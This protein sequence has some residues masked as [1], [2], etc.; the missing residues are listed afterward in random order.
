MNDVPRVPS[1]GVHDDGRDDVHTLVGAYALDAVDDVDRARVER[2]LASCPECAEELRSL[3]ETAAR[4]GTAAATDPPPGL[5]ARVLAE[6]ARTRQLPPRP[7][8][9]HDVVPARST[10]RA[11]E[12]ARLRTATRWLAAA[13]S[14]LLV[15][16][17]GLGALAWTWRQDAQQARTEA[18][19]L[20]GVLANADALMEA[21]FSTGGHGTMLVSGDRFLLVGSQVPPPPDGRVYK[22]WFID[23]SGPRPS[24]TLRRTEDGRYVAD[25]EGFRPGDQVAVSVETNPDTR[26]PQG[27]IVLQTAA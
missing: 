17:V 18:S 25:T 7:S 27:D 16:C 19:D 22:L 4:L 8:S 20:S 21:D 15:A 26:T 10:A 9:R 14:V 12:P 11:G 6:A 24:V 5:R 3:T 23:E 2:H 1:A 13:A